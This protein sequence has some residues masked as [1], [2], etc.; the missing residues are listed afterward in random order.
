MVQAIQPGDRVC[1]YT[2]AGRASG[3]VQ[4]VLTIDTQVAGQTIRASEGAPCYLVKDDQAGQEAVH[5]PE[6]LEKVD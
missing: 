6:S 3:V 5:K 1:W 4:K 2:A